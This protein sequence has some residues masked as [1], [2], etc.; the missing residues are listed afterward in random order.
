MTSKCASGTGQFL[1]NIARYLGIAQDEVGS[2]SMQADDPEMVS[3]ICTVLVETDVINMV[4]RGISSQN[5]LKGIHLS[6]AGRLI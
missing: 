2:L 3:S 6:M 1:Y 5:I 4:S